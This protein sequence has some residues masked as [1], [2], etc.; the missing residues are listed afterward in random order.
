[1]SAADFYKS[2]QNIRYRFSQNQKSEYENVHK[3]LDTYFNSGLSDLNALFT[4]PERETIKQ[5]VI[6]VI[7]QLVTAEMQEQF[8][9]MTIPAS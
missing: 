4:T 6:D 7:R 2:I 8:A 5:N 3:L 1:M 9:E